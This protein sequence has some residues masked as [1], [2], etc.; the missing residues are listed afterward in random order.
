MEGAEGRPLPPVLLPSFV[1]DLLKGRM[2]F[3]LF[4]SLGLKAASAKLLDILKG[5]SSQVASILGGNTDTVSV[6]G[7]RSHVLRMPQH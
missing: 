4:C 6:A 7:L 2:S 3:F 1:S 5:I